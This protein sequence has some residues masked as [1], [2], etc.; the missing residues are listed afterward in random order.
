MAEE[1]NSNKRIKIILAS[2]SPRRKL[3]LQKLKIDFDVIKPSPIKEVTYKNPEKTVITN[4]NFKAQFAFNRAII[5]N[6]NLKGT[7]IAGFDTIIWMRGKYYGKPSNN[8]LA[9]S[10]LMDFSGKSHLVLTG[11]TI[12]ESSTS[13]K[14]QGFEK[15]IVKFRK[16]NNNFIRK[17]LKVENVLDKAGAYDI[18]GYGSILIEKIKGCFYNVAGLPVSKFLKLLNKLGYDIL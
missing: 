6:L 5:N 11:V 8:F 15:T 10:Y 2:S 1:E 9:E 13:K 3:I 12:I 14:V 17:Y 4:S 7:I 18:Y 16:L